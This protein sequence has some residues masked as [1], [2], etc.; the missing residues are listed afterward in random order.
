MQ[1]PFSIALSQLKGKMLSGNWHLIYSQSKKKS[2]YHKKFLLN[3]ISY[4]VQRF[5]SLKKETTG[6]SH[7]INCTSKRS[8]ILFGMQDMDFQKLLLDVGKGLGQDELKALAFLCTELLR[9]NPN[10]VES[11]PHLFSSLMD[12]D[13]LSAEKPQLLTELLTIIQQPRLLRDLQLNA[14]ITSNYISAYRWALHA[15]NW[16]TQTAVTFMNQVILGTIQKTVSNIWSLKIHCRHVLKIIKLKKV[17]N[18]IILFVSKESDL[19]YLLK[20][21]YWIVFWIP[22]K[23][24][25]SSLAFTHFQSGLCTW[26][27]SDVQYVHIMIYVM[28]H[29]YKY[30]VYYAG[31]RDA[32]SF[33]WLST[34][35]QLIALIGAKIIFHV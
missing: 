34:V 9:R 17:L 24:F 30:I 6:I 1:A 19:L 28:V 8:C 11:F 21:S 23:V 16:D 32:S 12:K 15:N 14:Q 29:R 3:V 2:K 4:I 13:V 31:F 26:S 25:I 27:C 18:S 33:G 35:F 22:P 10:S 5:F 7:P 20:W